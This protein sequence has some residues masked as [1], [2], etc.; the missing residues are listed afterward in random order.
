MQPSPTET[1]DVAGVPSRRETIGLIG[2][3]LLGSAIA[4]R[5][6]EQ[7]FRVLGYDCNPRQCESLAADGG[8]AASS[9]VEVIQECRRVVLSLPDSDAV[10][11]VLSEVEAVLRQ[12]QMLIDTTTGA[13]AVA[14]ETG[15]RLA[16]RG[17]AYLD[18]A[19]C[20]NSEEL[21]RCEVL[22][23]AGGP[24]GA[25][26]SCRDVFASF[27]RSFWRM[28]DWGMGLRMKLTTNLVLGLNRAVLAEALG[29]AE[30]LGL[31]REEALTVLQQ[32]S[33]YSRVMDLKGRKMLTGDYE[34]Q[35]RL[36]QHLKDVR[37]ML[38]AGEGAD[39]RLP[40]TALHRQLLEQAEEAG[41]GGADNS[42]IA[43]VFRQ[44]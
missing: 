10:T 13:P 36:S 39:A 26:E 20:G 42:A 22:V 5:L 30:A 6:L 41:L 2:V 38:A 15:R 7:G 3:G 12:D 21:R 25:Y 28:G 11:Q 19:V 43:E 8:R 40:L 4:A 14:V 44:R 32:S 16:E 9:A 18:A 35:A 33:S 23:V 27:A 24:A 34:P 31:N 37:L 17:V 1:P 29:F